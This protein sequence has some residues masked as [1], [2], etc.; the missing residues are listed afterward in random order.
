MIYAAAQKENIIKK[1]R[2]LVVTGPTATGKTR[3]GI[4]LSQQLQGEVVS[5][6]SMQIYRGMDIGTAKPTK[7]E[8]DGVMH[9]MIDVVDMTEQYSVARYVE[10]AG[11]V[12]ADI[13]ARQKVPIIVGGTGLYIESLLAGRK[14]ENIPGDTTVRARLTEEYKQLGGEVLLQKLMEVDPI[15]GSKLH[16]ADQKRIVRALEVFFVTGKTITA[17]DEESRNIQS[18]YEATIYG[19][20]FEDRADLYERI[21]MRV[22]EMMQAGLKEEVQSLLARGLSPNTTAMQG[23]GYKELAAALQ[24][25]EDLEDAVLQIKR[26]SRRYAKRQLTWLRRNPKIKWILWKERANFEVTRHISTSFLQECG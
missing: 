26:E 3:M 15:R 17:H 13:L 20:N 2:I 7:E 16:A 4:L 1:P 10:E 21:D 5:A 18:P 9:H 12:I 24:N 8:M 23:I 14:F 11:A 25:G 6:D 22:D 19:L